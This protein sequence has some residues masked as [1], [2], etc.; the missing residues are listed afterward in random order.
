MGLR[1]AKSL[2]TPYGDFSLRCVKVGSGVRVE[3]SRLVDELKKVLNEAGVYSYVADVGIAESVVLKIDADVRVTTV[4]GFRDAVRRV[5]EGLKI[6][7]EIERVMRRAGVFN[8]VKV[9]NVWVGSSL[10][11][12]IHVFKD[13]NNGDWDLRA[14]TVDCDVGE[15]LS[16]GS[17]EYKVV[18]DGCEEFP[19]KRKVESIA[20]LC[21]G[22]E[23]VLKL[24]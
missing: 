5:A 1:G 23:E 15:R 22:V 3:V 2:L 17:V 9:S 4:E 12:Y 21:A 18:K 13:L 10:Q 19:V 24:I 11:V 8:S 7:A 14:L 16:L 6:I 20:E